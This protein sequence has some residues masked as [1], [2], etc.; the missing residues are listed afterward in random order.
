MD[1]IKLRNQMNR[2]LVKLMYFVVMEVHSLLL[3][4]LFKLTA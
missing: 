3:S 1:A 2:V 4:I